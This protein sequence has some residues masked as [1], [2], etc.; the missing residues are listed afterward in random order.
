M[1]QT[2]LNVIAISVFA[3]T[4]STLVGPLF[5]LP[6][7]VPAI[8]TFCLL[9]LATLDSFQW[10]GQGGTILLDL[11]AGSSK[12]RRDRILHHEAGHFLAAHL[13]GIPVTGYALNAWE[14]FRQGQSAQGGV[15]FEDEKL[16]S[17]LQNG[18]I[19]AQL[20]DQYC[21]VWMAGIVAE[22]LVYG[23]AEGGAED[24]SKISA[25]FTQLRRPSAEI[26][27]KQNWGLLQAKTL[28][29]SHKSAYEALVQAMEKRATVAECCGIIQQNL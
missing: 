9:G 21:I 4:L 29:E 18:T 3:I 2:S 19:S 5:N 6:P 11:L 28:I 8:A 15:R 25:I 17:Q 13:L 12:Q 10:Q 27:L 1:K 26:K 24:R 14:A 7:A 23:S 22:N 20:L 16:A